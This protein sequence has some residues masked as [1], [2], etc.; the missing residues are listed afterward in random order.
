MCL[1]NT[2][3]SFVAEIVRNYGVFLVVRISMVTSMHSFHNN[4][5]TLH[6]NDQ[7]GKVSENVHVIFYIDGITLI[8]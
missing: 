3:T 7:S 5:E 1:P 6:S 4:F 2:N 8:I